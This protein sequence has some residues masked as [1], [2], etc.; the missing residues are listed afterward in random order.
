MAE[1]MKEII[2]RIELF[3]GR[4][5]NEGELQPIRSKNANAY[6]V[7]GLTLLNTDGSSNFVFCRSEENCACRLIMVYVPED[8][9]TSIEDVYQKGSI[10]FIGTE[11]N[12]ITVEW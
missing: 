5:L 4:K 11:S 10:T 3:I 7:Y 12:S 8:V 1:N 2:D 6:E 9:A